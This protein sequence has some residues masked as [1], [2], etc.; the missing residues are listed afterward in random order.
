MPSALAMT[1]AEAAA[2]TPFSVDTLR[3]AIRET[4]PTAFPPPL[5]AKKDSRGR[6]IVLTRELERW[7]DSL[8]DA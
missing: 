3:R 6:Q 2:L 1:L 4:D 5:R 7:L 8:P